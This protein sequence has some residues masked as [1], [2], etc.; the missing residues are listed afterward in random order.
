MVSRIE[1][2]PAEVRGYGNIVEAKS[3]SDFVPV[4]SELS[5]SENVYSLTALE[6][7]RIT[8]TASSSS[9]S[10]GSSV[11]LSATVVD[12]DE[13]V[14]GVSVTFYD[15][16][17]SLGSATTNSNG[18]ATYTT[19]S[20]TGGSHSC[21]AV[22]DEK[23]SNSVS[24]TVNKLASTISLTVP[25]SGTV[26]TA[27]TVT[28]TLVPTSGSVKL[29]ENGSL[30]DTLT[31]TSGSFSKAVTQ[32]A[33]GTY[34]YYAVFEG[35]STYEGSTSSIQSITVEAIPVPSYN[36][37]SLSSNKSILSQADGESA[38]LT[39]QLLDGSSPASVGGVTVE[40]FNG[41]TS[42]GTATTNSNG[43]ATKSYTS[44]GVGDM[45]LTAEVDSYNSEIVNIEDCVVYDTAS[46]DK[47]SKYTTLNLNSLSWSTDHYVAYRSLGSSPTSTYYSQIYTDD[48]LPSN[49]EISMNIWASNVQEIQSG[50]CISNTHPQT[51]S[52][53][54]QAMLV[55]QGKQKGLM[56]RVNGSL[57]R[58]DNTPSISREAWYHFKMTV[59]GTSVTAVITDSNN[60]SVYSVTKTLSNISSWKKWNIQLGNNSHTIHWKNLKI[61]AL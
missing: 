30:K 25:A 29:Y 50:I 26:G 6:G 27:Y 60:N 32:N 4:G 37:V 42:L 39:A 28:G 41:L 12:D 48:E 10:Y 49:Y 2:I 19:S 59:Q 34:S 47:S 38:T 17:T 9:I 43:V 5:F 11:S 57:T 33:E 44:A 8:L 36:G 35:S 58:Y 55:Y 45:S 31:V 16:S 54:N 52:G 53:T 20:L 1:V 51:Y 46:T 22:Y 15:G 61:K 7:L 24:V 14:T 56:Y 18:V 21:T 23:T 13:P 40:F 3:L